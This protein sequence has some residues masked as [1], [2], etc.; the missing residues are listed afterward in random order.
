MPSDYTKIQQEIIADSAETLKRLMR[1]HFA[2]LYNDSTHFIYELLQNAEDTGATQVLISLFDDRLEFEHDGTLFDEADVS[3]I[4]KLMES[5]KEEDYTKIGRFG[6][7]FKSVY[8]HSQSPQIHSGD[9][10]FTIKDLRVPDAIAHRNCN[11]GTLFVLPFNAKNKIAEESFNEIFVRLKDLDVRT[12]LFLKNIKSISY[13]VDGV[14]RGSYLRKEITCADFDFV[15]AIKIHGESD[16]D[17]DL[18]ENWLVFTR[19]VPFKEFN[20]SVEIA[21]HI[22]DTDFSFEKCPRIKLLSKSTLAVY[23][24]TDKETHLGFLVQGPFRTTP[25]RDNIP[26]NDDFNIMLVKEAGQLIVETLLWLKDRNWLTVQVL[27]TMPL[28]FFKRDR[29]YPYHKELKNPYKN[30]LFEFIYKQVLSAL[31]NED[32]IPSHDGGYI[33]GKRAIMAGSEALRKL[34]DTSQL[35]QLSDVHQATWVS[36]DIS[37]DCTPILWQYLRDM[38]GVKVIEF[39]TLMSKLNSEFLE[40][41]SDQWMIKFYEFAN[42]LEYSSISELKKLPIIRRKDDTHVT[43]FD[44]TGHPHVFLPSEQI[45]R[46][47]TVKAELCESKGAMEFFREQ[48]GLQAPDLIDEVR[49]YIL[50]KY[51]SQSATVDDLEHIE[52]DIPAMLRAMRADNLESRKRQRLIEELR[53]SPILL[54]TNSEGNTRYCSPAELYF[55]NPELE[56]YFEDN[57]DIWFLSPIYAPRFDQLDCLEIATEIRVSYRDPERNGHVKIN[58][59]YYGTRHNPHKQGLNGFDPDTSADGLAFALKYPNFERAKVIWNRLLLRNKNRIKGTIESSTTKDFKKPSIKV[60]LSKMGKLVSESDWLPDSHGN[61]VVP[62]ELTLE[63]LPGDFMRDTDLESALGMRTD[64]GKLIERAYEIGDISESD[65]RKLELATTLTDEEID[66]IHK[67]R[68]I[69]REIPETLDVGNYQSEFEDAFDRPETRTSTQLHRRD[70]LQQE[71]PDDRRINAESDIGSEQDVRDRYQPAVKRDWEIKN[72]ETRRFLQN[73]YGGHCQ[74]CEDSFLKRDGTPYFEA[75]HIIHRT[76]AHWLDHPRNALCL[77]ANHS[78]Q[79]RH[80]TVSTPDD[81]V[82]GDIQ[83]S[84]EGQPYHLTIILCGEPQT[85]QFTA[86]HIDELRAALDAAELF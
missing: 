37:T 72:P 30:T 77:C 64:M 33:S 83:S 32:L 62:S 67:N 60:S 13:K 50:P 38:V 2:N 15:S 56:I 7:G 53:S 27:E 85:I 24:P 23:F 3:G 80:G 55:R 8:A 31:Q 35:S 1:N 41:Q 84:E 57:P 39:D 36:S 20:L 78:A 22:A 59:P 51:K 9:E 86:N 16:Q 79:Y 28:A 25:A 45:S 5:T 29:W 70:S 4:C 52:D 71:S 69:E 34:L 63:E 17:F 81:D 21:F 43:P 19:G 66:L 46:F 82:I 49:R 61:F 58:S 68:E 11:L 12:L 44:N 48:L 10:H 47:P 54:A 75:V 6:I 76:R 42:Q 14:A 65:K 73:E 40:K 18:E 26:K 74:I